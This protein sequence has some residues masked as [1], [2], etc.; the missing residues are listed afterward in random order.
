[1][2]N[3]KNTKSP[4]V[5]G[6][7]NARRAPKSRNGCLRCKAKRLKCDERKPECLQCTRKSA[8]CPGYQ[9]KSLV[10]STKHEKLMRSEG[11]MTTTFLATSPTTQS[12]VTFPSTSAQNKCDSSEEK[13]IDHL[14]SSANINNSQSPE[15]RSRSLSAISSSSPLAMTSPNDDPN[16]VTDSLSAIRQQLHRSTVPDFLLHLP[17]MLVEYY[18]SYVCQIFSS[19]DGTLNP[20]RSTVGKLWDGSA[21]IY[22]AIQSMAAAYLANHFPRMLPVGIQMQR[23]TY[24]CLYQVQRDGLPSSENLDKTLLTVLLVGQT[25]AWH[26]PN[27]LGLVHLK[28]AKRLNRKR[29]EQQAM[30]PAVA[31]D[32]RA[33]RQ[34]KFFEQCIRYW[35]MLA[36]FVEDEDDELGAEFEEIPQIVDVSETSGEETQVFPHPWMGVAPKAQILF[37]HVGRLIRR[38]RKVVARDAASVN[39][40]AIELGFDIEYPEDSLAMSGILARS[41]SLEEE[42][43]AFEP[44]LVSELVDAGD[45]NTPVQQYITLAESYRCAGLLQLYRIFPAL[46]LARVPYSENNFE[47]STSKDSISQPVFD[48]LPIPRSQTADEFIVSLAMHI[49]TLLGQLPPSSGTR[50][51]QPIVVIAAAA[52]LRFATSATMDAQSSSMPASSI[53]NSLNNR[54]IDI[55]TARRFVVTRLQ[56]FQLSLPAKPI[57]K[58]LELIKETWERSDL[59]QD[60]YWMDVMTDMGCASIFG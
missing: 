53:F 1:M 10:W 48:F 44:P 38:Y 21:P 50:C 36:G 58:A 31:I 4:I 23:E 37:A 46:L 60:V 33:S 11:G 19:F 8:V 3:P 42:L 45:E 6:P 22:Y 51:L 57:A 54:E 55:A 28:T 18:F 15:P 9:T 2:E 56:E 20:F 13:I 30:S 7:S 32:I 34:N 52:E 35:D 59:G 24:R 17:T 16:T 5:P 43:L 25:T 14:E 40:L 39:F 12:G 26:N 47:A 49:V 29:L 27:D 41:Q